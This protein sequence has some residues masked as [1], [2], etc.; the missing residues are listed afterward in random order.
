MRV[1]SNIWIEV[2]DEVALS[3]WRIDLLQA[4]QE[5][6]SISAAAARMDISY[7]RAWDKIHECE[8]RLGVKLLE[9]Q[10]GGSGGGGALLTA[11]GQDIVNRFKR[12]SAGLDAHLKQ[13][14]EELFADIQLPQ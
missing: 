14:F 9:T 11:A 8:N 3:R 13:R 6:G 7:H 1:R 12:L 2:D 5:T 4:V 10:V